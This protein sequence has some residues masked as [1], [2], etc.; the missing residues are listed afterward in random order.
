MSYPESSG[1]ASTD[2]RHEPDFAADGQSRE[3]ITSGH[4]SIDG[5]RESRPELSLLDQFSF[6]LRVCP[7][8]LL[9]QLPYIV[10]L[11]FDGIELELSLQCRREDD[12]DHVESIDQ[13]TV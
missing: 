8:K 1:S 10:R 11:E 4:R 5:N 3:V 12:V 13:K 9:E 2:R 7:G 6:E